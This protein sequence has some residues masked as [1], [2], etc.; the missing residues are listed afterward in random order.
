MAEI[1]VTNVLIGLGALA[2]A[3]VAA[4]S[5]HRETFPGKA[6]KVAWAVWF[7]PWLLAILSGWEYF[8]RQ[9]M[10]AFSGE[11]F[12]MVTIW[13]SAFVCMGLLVAGKIS[14]SRGLTSLR[15]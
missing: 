13:G 7:A 14:R 9:F 2:A 12:L 3:V 4:W 5:F 15:L 6:Q 11:P 8:K 1:L 10:L